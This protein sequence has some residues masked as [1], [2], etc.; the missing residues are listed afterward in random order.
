MILNKQF[1]SQKNTHC[2][3]CYLQRLGT[4]KLKFTVYDLIA[5]NFQVENRSDIKIGT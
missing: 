3:A 1:Q 5:V 2:K 4:E